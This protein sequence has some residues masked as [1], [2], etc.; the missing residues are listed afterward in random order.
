MECWLEFRKWL[1]ENLKVCGVEEWPEG[2]SGAL[3]DHLLKIDI[4]VSMTNK[5]R[6]PLSSIAHGRSGDKGD[7]VNIGLIAHRKEWF[8]L[9]Q[10][11]VTPE[12]LKI[13]FEGMVSGEIEVHPVPGIGAINCILN[14][15]LQGG[16]TVALRK[17][18][19][20]KMM[21]Q[22]ILQAEIE[23]EIDE[24]IELAIPGITD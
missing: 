21:G 17:D 6:I 11:Y 14:G 20:G 19:Q 4:G 18:A 9:I 1:P 13:I 7:M 10:K 3:K 2:Y 12:W 8:P 15:A 5:V 24:A 16:G 23:I 22:V